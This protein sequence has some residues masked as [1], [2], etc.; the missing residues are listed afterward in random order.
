MDPI[1]LEENN[2]FA[3]APSF[4]PTRFESDAVKELK[5]KYMNK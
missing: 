3:W 4:L 1:E 5:P 2:T